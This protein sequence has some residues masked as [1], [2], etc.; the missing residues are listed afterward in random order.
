M[1]TY[2]VPEIRIVDAWPMTATGK[3]QKHKLQ[4]AAASLQNSQLS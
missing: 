1:A 2:K 3:V 4:E